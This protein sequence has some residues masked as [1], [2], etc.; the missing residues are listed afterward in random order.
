METYILPYV[1]L[2]NFTFKI[3]FCINYTKES[4]F[5]SY[6]F[7]CNSGEQ[8]YGLL[9]KPHHRPNAIPFENQ[10]VWI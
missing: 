9:L 3:L 10:I 6:S 2:F 8:T 7:A 4:N 5:G 1:K